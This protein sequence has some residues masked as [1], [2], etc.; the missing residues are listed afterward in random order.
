VHAKALSDPKKAPGLESG[1]EG[2]KQEKS[3]QNIMKA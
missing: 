2:W 1:P 3:Q